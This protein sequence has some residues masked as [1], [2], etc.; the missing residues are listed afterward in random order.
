MPFKPT[1][2]DWMA[3]IESHISGEENTDQALSVDSGSDRMMIDDNPLLVAVSQNAPS[4]SIP[5]P[6]HVTQLGLSFSC[7]PYVVHRN[8]DDPEAYFGKPL[9]SMAATN[10]GNQL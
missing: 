9:S 5:K 3:F 10:Q 4:R 8:Y 7:C 2:K 6:R 1:D